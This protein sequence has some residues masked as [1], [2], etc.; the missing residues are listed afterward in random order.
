MNAATAF[1]LLISSFTR[2]QI[3]AIFGA[4]ILTLVP[5]M[6]FC[7]VLDPVSSLEG[8]GKLVGAIYPTTYYLTDFTRNF[9]KGT[10]LLGPASVLYPVAADWASIDRREHTAA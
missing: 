8:L 3:A 1:G 6:Q 5:A 2:S 9:F 7:G 4:A 10:G